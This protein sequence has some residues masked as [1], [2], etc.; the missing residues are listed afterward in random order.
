MRFPAI[1]TLLMVLTFVP[2][3][4]GAELD[5]DPIYGGP[6]PVDGGFVHHGFGDFDGDGS[7]ELFWRSRSTTEVALWKWDENHIGSVVEIDPIVDVL[8][9][10][11]AVGDFDDDGKADA[12]L[13]D[14]TSGETFIRFMVDGEPV[15]TVQ[16]SESFG[17]DWHLAGCGDFDGDGKADII[18]RSDDDQHF[19]RIW[20][21]DGAV[22]LSSESTSPQNNRESW[23]IQAV[24]DFDGNGTEDVLWKR[25]PDNTLYV[26]YMSGRQRQ[27]MQRLDVQWRDPDWSV[28]GAAD[29]PDQ[30]AEIYLRYRHQDGLFRWR[31]NANEFVGCDY[32]PTDTQAPTAAELPDN[33]PPNIV[34]FQADN[35][36]YGDLG[37]Y[38][39]SIHATPVIDQLAAQ[40]TRFTDYYSASPICTSARS[41]LLSGCYPRRNS[42]HEFFWSGSVLRPVSPEGIHDDEAL[43][44]EMLK[45]EGYF[46]AT[47]GKWHL[48][49]QFAFLP[50]QH[51]FD[52]FMG[53]L[54]SDEMDDSIPNFGW[55]AMPLMR[56]NRVLEAPTDVHDINRRLTRNAQ[57]LIRLHENEPMFLLFSL[58]TPG[59][60]KE[61]T[62]GYRFQGS[63]IN[64][65]YGD[66]IHE[67]DW[68]VGEV[69]KTLEQEGLA[70]N[71]I[72]IFTADNGAPPPRGT[73]FHGT[74]A[75]LKNRERWDASEGGFRV[76]MI[77]HW[78]NEIGSA[79]VSE[80]LV[81]S[82]DLFYALAQVGGAGLTSNRIIDGRDGTDL[83]LRGAVDQKIRETM[84]Y[85]YGEQLQAVRWGDWKYQLPLE[86]PIEVLGM[87]MEIVA[88]R[89]FSN[90]RIG[91]PQE[92][93]L[94]NLRNDIAEDENMLMQRPDLVMAMTAVANFAK[95]DLGDSEIVGRATRP[96][97]VVDFP[98]PQSR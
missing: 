22:V 75:P 38:G 69:R 49:D 37:C 42:M 11:Q 63:S 20:F 79:L 83:L 45:Q 28:V 36:G 82:M 58:I 55:P 61:P 67:I 31:F 87:G 93:G 34:L 95:N 32:L 2:N 12:V 64:G 72:I 71:T 46:T 8:L 13:R 94:F 18:W 6:F 15:E 25:S 41:A 70:E 91:P 92:A 7:T 96:V 24:A 97:G 5:F 33:S 90:R 53:L 39:S 21:M 74:N 50:K 14:H 43:L 54:Y 88:V 98:L 35:L 29:S 44:S 23:Q 3:A 16:T 66:C 56:D 30:T 78:P 10:V 86:E 59:S 48:G 19:I 89:G 17:L 40:G 81:T 26:W 47:F 62:P 51:G 85:Y 27:F 73:E 68:I 84:F 9:E 65:A 4:E 60:R 1:L 57:R 76:P 52:F 77:V 80:Q